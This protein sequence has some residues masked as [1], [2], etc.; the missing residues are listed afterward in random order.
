MRST[1]T[2]TPTGAIL[3]PPCRVGTAHP[4]S[5]CAHA[6]ETAGTASVP[7]TSIPIPTRLPPA[8]KG[9]GL[10]PARARRV[11]SR[12]T[13]PTRGQWNPS[14]PSWTFSGPRTNRAFAPTRPP[15]GSLRTAP[16]AAHRP[17]LWWNPTLPKEVSS[18][19]GATNRIAPGA[20]HQSHSVWTTSHHH[21]NGKDRAGPSFVATPTQRARA[22]LR[23]APGALP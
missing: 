2:F 3:L 9:K 21:L 12:T 19:T 18:P 5:A 23:I 14:P 20:A 7:P 8:R 15:R 22:T 11:L 4:A 16:G 13:T 10:T 17:N 6:T 1:R